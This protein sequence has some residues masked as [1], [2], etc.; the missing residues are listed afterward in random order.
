MAIYDKIIARAQPGGA[1]EKRGLGEI[2]TA[3]TKGEDRQ[4]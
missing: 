2:E 4:L 1:F 3:R